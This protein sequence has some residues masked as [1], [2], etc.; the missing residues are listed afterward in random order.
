MPHR[1]PFDPKRPLVAAKEFR[2]AGI[3]Y[4]PGDPFPGPDALDIALFSRRNIERQYNAFCVNHIEQDEAE[5][6][7]PVKMTGPKG[8]RY[9]ITAPWLDEPLIVRGK[10][11]AEKAFDDL[12]AAGPP[13]EL[14]PVEGHAASVLITIEGEK[15]IVNAPWLEAPEEFDDAAAAEARQG[16]LRAEGPP[17]GWVAPEEGDDENPANAGKQEGGSEGAGG[18][19]GTDDAEKAAATDKA[20]AADDADKAKSEAG[21]ANDAPAQS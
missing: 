15:F 8:G 11:N 1:E 3:K 14:D 10:V 7:D 18:A 21:K 17:D 2:F 9:T 20:A 4:G 19:P 5:A 13:K 6:D 12:K 16:E